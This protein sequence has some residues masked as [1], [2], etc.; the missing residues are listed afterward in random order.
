M[1]EGRPVQ[2]P[3][4]L[5]VGLQGAAVLLI[6]YGQLAYL[7][8]RKQFWRESW[9]YAQADVPGKERLAY[10]NRIYDLLEW[11]QQNIPPTAP[12]CC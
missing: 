10:G 1:G 12:F 8:E 3:M 7:P 9:Q 6:L 4:R 11:V 2:E 5:R